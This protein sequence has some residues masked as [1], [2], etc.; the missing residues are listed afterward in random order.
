M[1]FLL[2]FSQ[3]L[4]SFSSCNHLFNDSDVFK[5]AFQVKRPGPVALVKLSDMEVASHHDVVVIPAEGH[6]GFSV[7]LV[8]DFQ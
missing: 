5:W 4:Y 1:A 7:W 6:L 2:G 8:D 3:N